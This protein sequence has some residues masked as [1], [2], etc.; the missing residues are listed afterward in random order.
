MLESVPA[1]VLQK[2]LIANFVANLPK[3]SRLRNPSAAPLAIYAVALLLVA[4]CG[5]RGKI[6]LLPL[7]GEPDQYRSTVNTRECV[8]QVEK[9]VQGLRCVVAANPDPTRTH[10]GGIMIPLH[11]AKGCRIEMAF[12]DSEGIVIAHA[13]AYNAQKRRVAGWRTEQWA[14]LRREKTTYVFVPQ[15]NT[16]DFKP[17]PADAIGPMETLHVFVAVKPG[18]GAVFEVYKVEVIK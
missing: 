16:K 14:P 1:A 18:T 4:S 15:E 13:D 10:S 3:W 11:G 6:S 2:N 8:V 7:D 5:P 17:V 12:T 9:L